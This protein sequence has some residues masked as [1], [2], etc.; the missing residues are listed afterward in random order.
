L[1]GL[2]PGPNGGVIHDA[3]AGQDHY[4]RLVSRNPSNNAIRESTHAYG[5]RRGIGT[6]RVLVVEGYERWIT[7]GRG[8]WHP[9]A[10]WTGRAVGANGHAWESASNK[11]V[12]NTIQLGE[13][14]AVIYVLGE[15]STAQETFSS[16]EQ[17]MVK[18]F[19]RDGGQLFVTGA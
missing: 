8:T 9:Y 15:E 3:P 2:T 6:P 10:A 13:Y 1:D 19:L 14:D 17:E 11:T 4:Y 5:A 7:Q 16:A 18:T 12:G